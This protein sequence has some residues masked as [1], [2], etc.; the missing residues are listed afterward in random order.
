MTDDVAQAV[1]YL[2]ELCLRRG[3]Q[4]FQLNQRCE[5]ALDDLV[6]SPNRV[7]PPHWLV[8]DATRNATKKLQARTEIATVEPRGN[9]HLI[10]AGVLAQEPSDRVVW[11]EQLT[12]CD[13]ELVGMLALGF[14][15]ADLAAVEGT[16]SEA[17]YP[18][19]SRARA[20]ARAAYA[21]AA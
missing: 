6:R 8:R 9:V 11:F 4:N 18:R 19:L 5:E 12:H 21:A 20:R 15:A 3:R 17:V 10:D 16:T 13:R 2:Q 14:N 1:R 7:G